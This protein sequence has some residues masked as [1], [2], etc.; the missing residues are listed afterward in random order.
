MTPEE[1]RDAHHPHRGR[2]DWDPN[3]DFPGTVPAALEDD[4]DEAWQE[5]LNAET[6]PAPLE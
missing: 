2:I 4:S 1:Y 6:Q 3:C 5:F